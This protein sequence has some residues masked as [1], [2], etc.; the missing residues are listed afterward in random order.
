MRELQALYGTALQWHS[1]YAVRPGKLFAGVDM[2]LTISLFQ[3]TNQVGRGYTTK[4]HRWSN[5]RNTD[6]KHLFT[7]LTYVNNPDFP[8]NANSFPK[9]GSPVEI[10]ILS[11]M[12]MHG[13]KLRQYVV[14]LG[15]T[16]YYHSGG[17]YWRKALPSKLS[18]HYKPITIQSTL[19]PVV[20]ALL[21]SQ[22]F[23]W[24][25]IS[26]SNCMDLVSREVLELPVFPLTN[27]DVVR[28]TKLEQRLL[29]AYYENSTTRLRQ[30]ER[31]SVEELNFDVQQ[32]KPLIDEI[33]HLLAKNYGLSEDELDF[34]LNYDIKF[35]VSREESILLNK[36]RPYPPTH[37]R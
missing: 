4:Y 5:G 30:G 3:K 10:N 37:V 12:L 36:S 34:I 32:A 9:L 27:A 2:N 7:T 6:R 11:K 23:Y 14:P 16:L 29:S 31:I 35:R 19:S 20:F 28:F 13:R 18:S 17:R 1:H 33:D 21:N 26:N 15:I 8:T 25:W 24:Y 22:L